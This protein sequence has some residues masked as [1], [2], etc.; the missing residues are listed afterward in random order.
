M[1]QDSIQEAVEQA[2]GVC[3][4][5]LQLNRQLRGSDKLAERVKQLKKRVKALETAVDSALAG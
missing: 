1:R 4:S 5:V 3:K 2:R